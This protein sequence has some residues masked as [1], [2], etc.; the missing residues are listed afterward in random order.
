MSK[1]EFIRARIE[2]D[3]KN[4]V[5]EIFTNLGLSVTD[6]LTMF[7]KQVELHNGLPFEVKIPNKETC[8]AIN[9]SRLGI[10]M[11]ECQDLDDM[12]RMLNS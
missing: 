2:P 9:E 6:A 7:Y 10:N 8:K 1:S 12:L 5:E 11:T 3:L 4:K